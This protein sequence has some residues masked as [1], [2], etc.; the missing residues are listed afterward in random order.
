MYTQCP[1][2]DVAFR[3]TADVLRQAAG[4]VRCGGCGSAFNALDHLSE[5]NPSA[6]SAA[7]SA[8]NFSEFEADLSPEE[9]SER[10]AGDPPQSISAEQSAA[11]LK[12]LDQL[13][14]EE[15]RIED[16][17]VEWRV[18]DENDDDSDNL[19]EDDPSFT[20]TG[21]L[22]FVLQEDIDG[23]DT[24]EDE[25][26]DRPTVIDTREALNDAESSSV[27][28]EMRFDDNTPLPDEYTAIEEIEPDAEI[29]E[30]S[31]EEPASAQ[32]ASLELGEPDE[33]Q[34]LLGEVV[35]DSGD[36]SVEDSVLALEEAILQSDLRAGTGEHGNDEPAPFTNSDGPMDM[37]AQFAQQAEAMGI[38]LSGA[39]NLEGDADPIQ[40]DDAADELQVDGDGDLSGATSDEVENGVVDELAIDLT[41]EVPDEIDVATAATEG[42]FESSIDEDLIA[43]AF[44]AEA[45]TRAHEFD[46]DGDDVAIHDDFAESEIDV[47]EQSEEE[48]T[49]NRL[50]DQDLLALAIEDEDG[51][52]STIVQKQISS[53]DDIP[54][55]MS[56][57]NP[58]VETIIMEGDF[59]RTALEEEQA[60]LNNLEEISFA[61]QARQTF[62]GTMSEAIGEVIR[63]GRRSSDP[64]SRRKIAVV[65]SLFVVLLLQLVHQSREALARIPLFE[66]SIAPV[67]RLLGNP[68]TPAWDIRGWRFEATKGSSDDDQLLT[69]YSRIGNTSEQALPYPLLHVSLTDR[70]EEIIGSRV[71]EPREYLVGDQN[72]RN[73]VAPGSNFNAVIAVDTPAPAATGFK[74]NVCYRLSDGQLRCAVESFR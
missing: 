18:L 41:D 53:A 31:A 71:L 57:N 17:G 6:Q 16:T 5:V 63:G 30:P 13:A 9:S 4:K 8:Q 69:I 14:G 59:V 1:E 47:P 32:P 26:D 62:S 35:E 20:D 52:A 64:P 39:H 40:A 12:T 49:V 3:V 54:H 33:W 22:S 29:V 34:D 50:I 36:E 46:P 70:F 65:V 42:E 11:L 68:V 48:M 7:D 10:Q 24:D 45:A 66:K 74:L 43:A 67:Y 23:I 15:I 56:S 28:D 37:D 61:K 44:E 60:K 73:T 25:F 38:D 21:S 55:D 19:D 2:C 51:F 58:L 72:A 27:R